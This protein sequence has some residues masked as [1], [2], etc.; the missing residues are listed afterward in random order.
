MNQALTQE[1][2]AKTAA[3]AYRITTIDQFMSA[4]RLYRETSERYSDDGW[5]NKTDRALW[6]LAAVYAAGIV[7]GKREER[8]RRKKGAE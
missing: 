7:E 4:M 2:A 5:G 1:E 8:S 6:A 3:I